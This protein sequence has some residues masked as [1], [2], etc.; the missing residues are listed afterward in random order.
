MDMM[1]DVRSF[2]GGMI[3][4]MVDFNRSTPVMMMVIG[5]RQKLAAGKRL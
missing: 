2:A 5:R 3:N 1:V 4:I